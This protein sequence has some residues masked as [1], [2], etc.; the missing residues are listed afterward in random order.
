MQGQ[1]FPNAQIRVRVS[2]TYRWAISLLLAHK[3]VPIN[4]EGSEAR[5]LA[6]SHVNF[7]VCVF[8]EQDPNMQVISVH[9]EKRFCPGKIVSTFE[10]AIAM[11]YNCPHVNKKL[12]QIFTDFLILSEDFYR[13]FIS[14]QTFGKFD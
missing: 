11:H 4:Y 13:G 12:P 5:N 3:S 8:A 6:H 2:G 1:Q 10:T 7:Y 9:H 14:L